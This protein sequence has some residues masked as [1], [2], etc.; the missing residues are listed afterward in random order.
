MQDPDQ[1]DLDELPAVLQKAS[2][3][4]DSYLESAAMATKLTKAKGGKRKKAGQGQFSLDVQNSFE[5]LTMVDHLSIPSKSH[6]LF[7]IHAD[8]HHPSARVSI[9]LQAEDAEDDDDGTAA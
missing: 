6:D 8:L 2:S 1:A 9:R 7:F 3:I 4:R 5:N